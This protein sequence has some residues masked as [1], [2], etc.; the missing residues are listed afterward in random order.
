MKIFDDEK[1]LK[2]LHIL[3]L[4]AWLV[5]YILD[6]P[7]FVT[8]FIVTMIFIVI[9]IIHC[10][11]IKAYKKMV[12]H[13]I[14]PNLLGMIITTVA[15]ELTHFAFYQDANFGPGMGIVFASI[16]DVMYIF[17]LVAIIAVSFLVLF[18]IEKYS[19]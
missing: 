14:W 7:Q 4:V 16:W 17:L 19:N 2:R 11:V 13:I 3:I 9:D 10:R 15:Y 8:A 6:V 18:V 12:L 1:L 5:P